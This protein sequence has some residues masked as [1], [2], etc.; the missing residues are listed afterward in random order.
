[1][2]TTIPFVPSEVLELVSVAAQ[3][4]LAVDEVYRDG[5]EDAG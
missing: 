2:G 4:H 1:V 3:A 5:L